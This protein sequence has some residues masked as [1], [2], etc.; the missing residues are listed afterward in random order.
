MLFTNVNITYTTQH[1][2]MDDPNDL[3]LAPTLFAFLLIKASSTDDFELKKNLAR[4][5][6]YPLSLICMQ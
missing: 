2:M 4:C 1:S 5:V 6:T 3:N